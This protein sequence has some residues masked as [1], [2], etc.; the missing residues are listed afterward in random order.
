MLSL[1]AGSLSQLSKQQEPKAS[2]WRGR[3][4]PQIHNVETTGARVSFRLH[5]IFPDFCILFLKLPLVIYLVFYCEMHDN[6][7]NVVYS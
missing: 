3:S 5:N 2:E 7:L 1:V 4:P 6:C